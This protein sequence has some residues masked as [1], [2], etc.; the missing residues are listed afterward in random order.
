[1]NCRPLDLPID[2]GRGDDALISQLSRI[3]SGFQLKD[4]FKLLLFHFQAESS[5]EDGKS[6]GECRWQE[7]EVNVS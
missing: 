6:C 2:P 4:V 5:G 7:K 1:M 3:P